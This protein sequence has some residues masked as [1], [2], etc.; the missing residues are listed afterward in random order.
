EQINA[1]K[2]E[3]IS[4]ATPER[5]GHSGFSAAEA[6]T[7]RIRHRAW[8]RG[9]KWVRTCRFVQKIQWSPPIP[10]HEPATS[11]G[12]VYASRVIH[13]QNCTKRRGCLSATSVDQNPL[14]PVPRN[15]ISHEPSV[16]LTG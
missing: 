15:A 13:A 9:A 8:I 10:L 14:V 12:T 2:S 4:E 1:R 5:V 3:Y 6:V 7:A 16:R 11:K